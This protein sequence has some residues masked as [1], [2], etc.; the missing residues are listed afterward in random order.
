MLGI[1]YLLIIGMSSF[2]RNIY[3][4]IFHKKWLLTDRMTWY[5]SGFPEKQADKLGGVERG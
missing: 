1:M 2:L 3:D 5:Y 4:R